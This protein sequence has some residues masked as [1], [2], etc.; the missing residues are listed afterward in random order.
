VTAGIRA[1]VTDARFGESEPYSLGIE[2]E[3]M[4]LDAETFAQVPRVESLV[5]DGDGG[6][7]LKTELFAS[8][9]ELNTPICASAAEAVDSV[10]SLRA[11]GAAAA[12]ADGLALAAAGTHPLSVPEQQPIAGEPRYREFVEYAGATARRQGVN[13][14][15]VHVGMASGDACLEVLEGVLPWLPVVLALSA[16]SPY[17]A[18]A[19]TGMMSIR[20]EILG[21]LPRSGAPPAF[22][23]YAGW[24]RYV[25][26]MRA[27][28][29][30]LTRDYTSFWWDVR[31]HP[32]F[33]TLEIRMPD[34][35]TSVAQTGA[36]AALLQA[37][38]KTVGEE[39]PR[40]PMERADYQQNRWA[41]A[42]FGPQ[43]LLLHPDGMGAAAASELAEELI[44]LVAP[45][46]RELAS[47]ELIG[48]LDPRRC[49]A[50]D[51]LDVGRHNGIDAVC[52]DLVERTLAR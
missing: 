32:R 13:G 46:A 12:A 9:V 45:A 42:R 28:G 40:E 7:R 17:L 21:T 36:L 29:V 8:V 51:Q 41:A 31:P 23:S 24:E 11:Q 39:A 52:R 5:G 18:G 15:H 35:P 4:I 43:A 20:T 49:E 47:S 14:L 44:H 16:S 22:G 34:Q 1:G 10:R 6:G 30:P 33:G 19:E 3:V 50:E 38:C 48:T 37:L 25:E 26:R 2:E 27:S